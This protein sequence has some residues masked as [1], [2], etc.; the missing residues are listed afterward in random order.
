MKIKK[1][2]IILAPL[3]FLLS[4]CPSFVTMIPSLAPSLVP[5]VNLTNVNVNTNQISCYQGG[6]F[7]SDYCSIPISR[8]VSLTSSYA[9]PHDVN[10]LLAY[11]LEH[12]QEFFFDNINHTSTIDQLNKNFLT[13]YPKPTKFASL[14]IKV[15][16]LYIKMREKYIPTHD[17]KNLYSSYIYLYTISALHFATNQCVTPYV[18]KIN[19][20]DPK[21]TSQREMLYKAF[22]IQ[23]TNAVLHNI[24]PNV[25]GK[26]DSEIDLYNAIYASIMKIDPNQLQNMA[27]SIYSRTSSYAPQFESSFYTESG[28]NFGDIGSFGCTNLGGV[29][30]KYGYQYFGRN[31]S[32]IDLR[33]RFIQHDVLAQSSEQGTDLIYDGKESGES[34]IR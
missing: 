22:A 25:S 4:G 31:V 26:Y 20:I 19:G 32:G 1:T 12:N 33:V 13:Y 3:S 9:D 8:F 7:S 5:S 28:I 18:S 30:S 11:D 17:Y 16:N 23:Y 2:F 6:T 29:W 21:L 24:A 27:Q 15:Q 10:L 14:P 34:N